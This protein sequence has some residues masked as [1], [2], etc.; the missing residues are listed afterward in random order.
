MTP[1]ILLPVHL[2]QK[3]VAYT[4]AA[5]EIAEGKEGNKGEYLHAVLMD[6]SRAGMLA[7]GKESLT[8]VSRFPDRFKRN[9]QQLFRCLDL[10][11]FAGD[12]EDI[13]ILA[14][15]ANSDDNGAL[16]SAAFRLQTAAHGKLL[17][18]EN[19][20]I[21]M[22]EGAKKSKKPLILGMATRIL[23]YKK[24]I[25][26]AMY[27]DKE[28]HKDV[29]NLMEVNDLRQLEKDNAPGTPDD[30]RNVLSY[31]SKAPGAV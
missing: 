6:M 3:T 20:T 21:E 27:G 29:K 26:L 17:E 23:E 4:N 9:R 28:K 12:E 22:N 25:A 31:Y 18:F 5:F 16:K 2:N 15:G 24:R 13:R 1:P 8:K 14:N 19:S 7:D 11:A 10:V 30:H